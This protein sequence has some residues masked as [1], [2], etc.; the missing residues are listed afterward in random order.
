MKVVSVPDLVDLTAHT[1]DYIIITN[2]MYTQTL[3]D[4][5]LHIPVL[6]NINYTI[7]ISV[8]GMGKKSV[9]VDVKICISVQH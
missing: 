8:T 5:L 7:G 2:A 1:I 9:S 6:K 4:F 3:G